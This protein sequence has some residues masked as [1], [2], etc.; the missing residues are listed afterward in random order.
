MSADWQPLERLFGPS[1]CADFMFMGRAEQIHLYKHRDTRRY[2]NIAPDETCFRH[3][4]HGYQPIGLE[5]AIQHVLPLRI[6]RASRRNDKG[7]GKGENN[8]GKDCQ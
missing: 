4:T 8:H 2:L 3:S 5:E 7:V 6:T 1:L